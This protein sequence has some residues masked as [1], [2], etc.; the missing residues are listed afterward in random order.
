LYDKIVERKNMISQ[1]G[2]ISMKTTRN[3]GVAR[4]LGLSFFL[5]V[6][7]AAC[8]TTQSASPA[9]DP[10]AVGS[11]SGRAAGDP[12]AL[13]AI[14]AS[15]GASASVVSAS[16]RNTLVRVGGDYISATG[17]RCKRVVLSEAATGKSQVSAVCFVDASWMTVVGL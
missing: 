6:G 3:M 1:Q 7:L 2:W 9:L 13:Y 8:E 14:G 17:D 5:C 15:Q 4:A 12:V 16:G 11:V 10:T